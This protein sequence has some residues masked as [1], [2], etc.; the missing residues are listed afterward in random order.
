M[1]TI[2]AEGGQGGH[3]PLVTRVGDTGLWSAELMLAPGGPYTLNIT[4]ETADNDKTAVK[5]TDVL[6]GDVWVRS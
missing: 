5:L 6:A 4:H 3:K 2:T 1:V